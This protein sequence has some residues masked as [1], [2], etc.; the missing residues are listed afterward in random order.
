MTT[1]YP[2]NPHAWQV[3]IQNGIG[4]SKTEG[5]NALLEGTFPYMQLEQWVKTTFKEGFS[6]EFIPALLRNI[7][8]L[9][10]WVYG[11]GEEPYW[12]GA[13]DNG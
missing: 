2:Q 8:G 7:Q 4:I 13:D 9:V 10:A 12:S 3:A 11:D 1:T 6:P 5:Q